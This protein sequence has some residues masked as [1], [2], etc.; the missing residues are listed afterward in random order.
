MLVLRLL[1]LSAAR[2]CNGDGGKAQCCQCAEKHNESCILKITKNWVLIKKNVCV[3]KGLWL[4]LGRSVK[5]RRERLDTGSKLELVLT[6]NFNTWR[7]LR[8][9]CTHSR[10][11][12]A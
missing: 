12:H 11:L 8:T 2:T 6:R 10:T 3:Q 9:Y 1:R 4:P 7:M 5:R